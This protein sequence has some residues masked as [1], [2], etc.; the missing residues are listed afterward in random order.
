MATR[1]INTTE[2]QVHPNIYQE[3]IDRQEQ[4]TTLIC[5]TIG[6]QGRALKN[7]LVEEILAIEA[8]EGGAQEIIPLMSGYRSAAAW[9]NGDVGSAALMVG[10]SV[11]LVKDVVSCQVL[12]DRMV[13]EAKEIFQRNLERF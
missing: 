10:Q 4:D 2:C 6:M 8:R 12:L 7:R 9:E 5:K 13:A 11:G 1:F 3:M